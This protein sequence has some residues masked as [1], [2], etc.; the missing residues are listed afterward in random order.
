MSFRDFE[1]RPDPDRLYAMWA[2]QVSREVVA[3]SGPQ[4][5]GSFVRSSL[6][7]LLSHLLLAV[8]SALTGLLIGGAIALG[9]DAEP[10]RDVLSTTSE[11][12]AMAPLFVA[13]VFAGVV[14]HVEGMEQRFGAAAAHGIGVAQ[15]VIAGTLAVGGSHVVVASLSALFVTT[16]VLAVFVPRC[17]EFLNAEK[18]KRVSTMAMALCVPIALFM[19]LFFSVKDSA[20]FP[21]TLISALATASFVGSHIAVVEALRQDAVG[22]RTLL[23]VYLDLYGISAI[24]Y[25]IRRVKGPTEWYC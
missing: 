14:V 3:D 23:R 11:V 1:E 18:A 17:G 2:A 9:L 25:V 12:L 10:I 13:L 16:G 20:V 22:P 21:V 6:L 19:A 15:A 24:S 8:A 5:V 4:A 7:V